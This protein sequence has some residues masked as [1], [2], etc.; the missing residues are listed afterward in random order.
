[1][2]LFAVTLKHKAPG[3]Y[4]FGHL[5]R[6]KYKGAISYKDVDNSNGFWQFTAD[7]YGVGDGEVKE[8]EFSA[9]AGMMF[10]S[11]SNVRS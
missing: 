3:S 5:D 1:M 8:E 6:S 2:P 4:D 11:I 10:L 9:M 7:G